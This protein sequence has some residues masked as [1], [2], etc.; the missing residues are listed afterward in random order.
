MSRIISLSFLLCLLTCTACETEQATPTPDPDPDPGPVLAADRVN[1]QEPKVG[2]FNTFSV[3]GFEC[4]EAVPAAGSE[5]TL[6]ITAV[7]ETEIAFAETNSGR[8]DYAYTYTADRVPGNLLISAEERAQSSL[9]YFY[10]SDSIRLQAESVA[11]L[12]YED[13]VFY[14]GSEVF[15]GDYVA[16]IPSFEFEASTYENLKMVSCVPIILD[17]DGYLL[18]DARSLMGSITTSSSEFGGE[19]TTFSNVY[20][21]QDAWE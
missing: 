21:L 3:F 12:T 4:G 17:L 6:T 7:S 15:K 2:Q 10:G 16:S 20:L 11:D 9:F 13:C 5:L 14:D 8:P 19:V 1:F 18:Y